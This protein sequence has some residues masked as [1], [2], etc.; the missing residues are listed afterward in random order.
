[1]GDKIQHTNEFL[2]LASSIDV[3]LNI[4]F[5]N[6]VKWISENMTAR[7]MGIA[8]SYH[9]YFAFGIKPEVEVKCGSC[10]EVTSVELPFSAVDVIYPS[11]STDFEEFL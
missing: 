9:N 1:M 6:K 2:L 10:S 5:E 3:G 7:E 11:V 4:P 8:R